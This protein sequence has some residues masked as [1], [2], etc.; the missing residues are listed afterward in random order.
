MCGMCSWHPAWLARLLAPAEIARGMRKIPIR[1]ETDVCGAPGWI[2]GD[3]FLPDEGAALRQVVLFC[4]PGGG[5]TRGYFDI[6]GPVSFSFVRAMTARGL[7][8]VTF[9]HAGTGESS[10][11]DDGFS[12]D[13]ASI[14]AAGADAV[15]FVVKELR[16][17]RI[18]A[19]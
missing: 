13:A 10:V 19:S 14:A 15:R 6:P 9:D 12:L 2:C 18:S 1:V 16:L 4:F 5:V 3:I 17:G 8:C 7:V 11:P